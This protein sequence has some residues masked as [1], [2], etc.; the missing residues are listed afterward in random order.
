MHRTTTDPPIPNQSGVRKTSFTGDQPARAETVMMQLRKVISSV[1]GPYVERVVSTRGPGWVLKGGGD[2]QGCMSEFRAIRQTWLASLPMC[3]RLF[4]P[5]ARPRA[6][7]CQA[8][9][10]Q[11]QFHGRTG[12][13]T[14]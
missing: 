7:R 13:E 2:A 11:D 14:E 4:V 5:V 12:A 1:S 10:I 3:G 8:E 6:R 9:R